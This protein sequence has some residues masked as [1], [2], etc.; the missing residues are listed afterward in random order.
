MGTEDG[1]NQNADTK[2]SDDSLPQDMF[3][4]FSEDTEPTPE[5]APQPEEGSEQPSAQ[6]NGSADVDTADAPEPE[7]R[8]FGA[9]PRD[10]RIRMLEDSLAE[11]DKTLHDYIRAH[12]RA[13]TEFESFKRRMRDNQSTEVDAARGKVVERLLEVHDNLQRSLDASRL[14]DSVDDLRAGV[15]LVARQFLQ[16]LE[17]LGLERFDPINQT[18]DPKT[19]EAMGVVPVAEAERDGKVIMTMKPGFK[20]RGRELR[21]AMVQVGRKF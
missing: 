4:D 15:E 20:Y 13:Q 12:K 10:A 17:E 21:P 5:A 9:D 7:K 11:R 19:M 1:S 16:R 3:A 6:P 14:A 8:G 2:R 18:F